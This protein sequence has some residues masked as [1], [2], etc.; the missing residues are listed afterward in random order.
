MAAHRHVLHLRVEERGA[1]TAHTA[2][3]HRGAHTVAE[4]VRVVGVRVR[5]VNRRT[6]PPVPLS[7]KETPEMSTEWSDPTEITPKRD[8]YIS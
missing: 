7:V 5:V 4:P 8:L 3:P 6:A 1:G 2:S